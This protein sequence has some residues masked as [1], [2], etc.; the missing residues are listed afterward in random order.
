MRCH[1]RLQVVLAMALGD[2]LIYRTVGHKAKTA[3]MTF[4]HH[5]I[6]T[7]GITPYQIGSKY[8]GPRR[9]TGDHPA[10]LQNVSQFPLDM[11]AQV[12]VGQSP[13]PSAINE[14]KCG[15]L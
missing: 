4:C 13:L 1:Y 12:G 14:D 9:T 8:A 10:T 7:T 6:R 2:V 15:L 3:L 11:R 5:N